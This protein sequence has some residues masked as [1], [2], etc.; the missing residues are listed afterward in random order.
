MAVDT[1]DTID[2]TPTVTLARLYEEQGFVDKAADIYRRLIAAGQPDLEEVLNDV[3]KRLKIETAEQ[4]ETEAILSRLSDWQRA[5]HSRK[6]ILDERRKKEGRILVI[7]AF[8]PGT[9]DQAE[10]FQSDGATVDQ[11]NREIERT[12]QECRINAQT[13]QSNQEWELVQMIREASEGY[14]VVIIN[15]GQYSYTSAAI[16]DALS[17]LEIPIIEV[18]LSNISGQEPFPQKSLI[19]DVA[20]AHLAGFGIE[21]YLMAVRAA[22]NMTEALD[23]GREIQS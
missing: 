12:A 22:R 5:I 11:I 17:M 3:K 18:Q 4:T 23:E 20:T 15:A 2:V 7:H 16:R 1:D 19:A 8:N 14:D 21:G 9:D 10:P 13:F 6:K